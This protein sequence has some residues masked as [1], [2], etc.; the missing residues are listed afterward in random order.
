MA[1][2][3]DSVRVPDALADRQVGFFLL[4]FVCLLLCFVL[5]LNKETAAFFSHFECSRTKVCLL[6]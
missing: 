3:H 1:M 4:L 2:S 5:P 6:L